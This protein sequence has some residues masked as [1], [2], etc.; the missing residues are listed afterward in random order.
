MVDV[1]RYS[2]GCVCVVV[3]LV[4]MNSSMIAPLTYLSGVAAR[5]LTIAAALLNV[6][7]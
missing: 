3:P 6:Q 5:R 7:R 1:S 2:H 4:T